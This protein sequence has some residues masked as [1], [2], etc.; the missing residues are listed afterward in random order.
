M[1]D[2]RG[3]RVYWRCFRLIILQSTPVSPESR[4]LNLR[5]EM[6]DH[7]LKQ[8]QVTNLRF[9][10]IICWVS[11]FLKYSSVDLT[12]DCLDCYSHI[13]D[14]HT[15]YQ[16]KI[17]TKKYATKYFLENIF[18]MQKKWKFSKIFKNLKNS[19]FFLQNVWK[20]WKSFNKSNIS[21]KIFKKIREN[22]KIF[23]KIAFF[24]YRK[25]SP[26]KIVA[27]FLV[28]IFFLVLG[29]DI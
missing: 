23:V 22:P 7:C 13:L 27:Y 16:K 3:P 2:G 24:E 26:K 17:P 19:D 15:E 4:P 28:G 21:E 11:R 29:M 20:I 9:L 14:V 6:T 12:G 5:L 10:A 1:V 25:C 18:D 8:G